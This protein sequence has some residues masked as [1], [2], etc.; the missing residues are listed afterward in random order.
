VGVGLNPGPKQRKRGQKGIR[1]KGHLVAGL[2]YTILQGTE[3]AKKNLEDK[4]KGV[5]WEGYGGKKQIFEK[6]GSK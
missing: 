4:R 1:R 2:Q 5:Q 3:R 6:K